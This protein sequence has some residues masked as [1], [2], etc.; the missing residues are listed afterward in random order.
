MFENPSDQARGLASWDLALPTR[1]LPVVAG[2]SPETLRYSHEL[3]WTLEQG[4]KAQGQTVVVLEDMSGLSPRDAT[5]GHQAVLRRWLSGI[6]AGC[7]V[8]L[9]A[10]LEA[11]AVLLA[12][13]HARPLVALHDEK[14]ALI[15]A[16]NAVKVLVQAAGLESVLLMPGTGSGERR[17]QVAQAVASICG[18]RLGSVPAVWVLGYDDQCSGMQRREFDACLLRVLDCALMIDEKRAREHVD[19]R[20]EYRQPTADPII[21]ASDVHRQRHAGP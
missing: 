8:L 4:L 13:S 9:H 21:G 18:Q 7:V 1:V 11:L 10:P 6:S 14:R 2:D 5:A 17:S 15:W 20:F 12:D 16:Y 3:L 19:Q